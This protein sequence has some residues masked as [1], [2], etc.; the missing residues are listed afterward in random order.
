MWMDMWNDSWFQNVM[1]NNLGSEDVRK[2]YGIMKK[3]EALSKYT[4]PEHPSSDGYYHVYVA[5]DTRKAGRRQLKSKTLEG[6]VEKLYSFE[7]S[8]RNSL[9]KTFKD[10]FEIVQEENSQ[11]TVI[12][13]TS[14]IN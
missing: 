12:H 14:N 2:L 8:P 13:L 10:V 9:T 3:K 6:L 5:D 11:L 1:H 4:F 7:M